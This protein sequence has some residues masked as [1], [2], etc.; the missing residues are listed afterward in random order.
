[1]SN[2]SLDVMRGLKA[3]GFGLAVLI[4]PLAI[5]NPSHA[6]QGCG[7][8]IAGASCEV[9]ASDDASERAGAL[10]RRA[11]NALVSNQ[12]R[13]RVQ[14]LVATKGVGAV[15]QFGGKVYATSGRSVSRA[16]TPANCR[17]L[18]YCLR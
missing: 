12:E 5:S 10:T 17:D 15:T 6:G 14:T 9:A 18:R 8:G 1:M 16:F 2:R 13:I 11:A 3:I 7:F 4:A